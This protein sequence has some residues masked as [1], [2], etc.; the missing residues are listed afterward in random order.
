MSKCTY[1]RHS[2]GRRSQIMTHNCSFG[3]SSKFTLAQRNFWRP[4][5]AIWTEEPISFKAIK[6]TENRRG[7]RPCPPSQ[8]SEGLPAVWQAVNGLEVTSPWPTNGLT[9]PVFHKVRFVALC[10]EWI[11]WKK[12]A[13]RQQEDNFQIRIALTLNHLWTF[14]ATVGE[15]LKWQKSVLKHS[16]SSASCRS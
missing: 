5:Y 15:T 3:R 4:N 13:R 10:V 9:T 12:L 1:V 11:L 8:R 7:T 6:Q 16:Q 2:I 14:R